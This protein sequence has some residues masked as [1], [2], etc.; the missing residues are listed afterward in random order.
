MSHPAGSRPAGDYL[1]PIFD[2]W[3]AEDDPAVVVAL[4]WS[5][6]SG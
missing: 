4:S 1:I 6:C 2:D 3:F 5:C